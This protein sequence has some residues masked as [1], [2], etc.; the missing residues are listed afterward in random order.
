MT[1][2]SNTIFQ[3]ARLHLARTFNGLSLAELGERVSASRQ[4][5]QRLEGDTTTFPSRDMLHALAEILFVEPEFFFEP[6]VGQVRE[7]ECHFRKLRT[8]PQNV[9]IR[10]LT[11]GTIFSHIVSYLEQHVKMPAVNIPAIRVSGREDIERASETCRR[12]WGLRYDAPIHNMTRTLEN[13]GCVVTTFEGVSDKIDAFSYVRSR[14]F[15]VRSTDK[16]SPSRSRFD[17]AHEC[18]HI[19]MHGEFEVGDPEL[20]EQANQ[21]ASAFL[22]PRAAFIREFPTSS[23]FNW[24]EIINLKKRWGVSIQAIIRRAHDLGLISALQ[25]RNAQVYISRN[26]WRHGE[27]PETEPAPEPT[28][29][30]PFAFEAIMQHQ[31]LTPSQIAQMLHMKCA[32]FEKFNIACEATADMATFQ[33]VR[34]ASNV[35]SLNE[36]RQKR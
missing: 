18:G 11:Y 24:H 33:D 36:H 6:I 23:R 4:Y 10:A 25:Y 14:P 26:G 31:G 32:I 27:P 8:T 7:E 19:V 20:E 9:R 2:D 15:I 12:Q 34:P 3:G 16:G 28:E 29:I 1:K 30:I 5:M 17:L 22:L 35:V 21:F 13:F